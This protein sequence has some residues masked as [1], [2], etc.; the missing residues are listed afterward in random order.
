MAEITVNKKTVKEYLEQGQKS[1]FIIPEYQREYSWTND[2]CETLWEDVLNF[3]NSKDKEY[4]IGTIV[5]FKNDDGNFEIIDGQQRTT[6]LFLLLRAIY[7]KLETMTEDDNVN[8]LKG[9]IAP[10][11]WKINNITRK[12]NDFSQTNIKSL[13]ATDTH[14][15]VFQ[16]IL[17]KGKTESNN[18]NFGQNYQYF[19][20]KI[21][22]FAGNEPF[23]F[24]EFIVQILERLI[25][26]PIEADNQDSALTIFSTLNDRGLS[27]SDSD[28][29]K[30][31]I[32]K[33]LTDDDKEAFIENWKSLSERVGQLK[34]V[35][36]IDNLFYCYMMYIRAGNGDTDTTTPGLRKFYSR[37]NFEVLNQKDL[38][39]NILYLADLF[40]YVEQLSGIEEW[41][42]EFEINKNIDIL[43][44]FPNEWWKYPLC[45]FYLNHRTRTDF[46]FKFQI[47]LEQFVK[48]LLTK[49]AENPSVNNIKGIVLEINKQVYG[50]LS[51]SLNLNVK[52]ED[53]RRNLKRRNKFTKDILILYTYLSGEV[54]LLPEITEIEHILPQ[55]NKGILSRNELELAKEKVDYLGNKILLEKKINIKA[56]NNYFENKKAEYHKSKIVLVQKL[57][58]QIQDKFSPKMID[59]RQVEIENTILN[60]FKNLT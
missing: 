40:E 13:S 38:F 7:S 42:N 59:D 23:K 10:C 33:K 3:Y 2:E 22:D 27:L 24:Y 19:G 56:S 37:D 32:Y 29:F 48:T 57:A 49:F 36:N 50:S 12:A 46:K 35:K 34:V 58:N 1:K 11:L 45:T 4:F 47:F 44:N 25:L 20:Q 14:N 55:N 6:T 8:G 31:K 43:R 17:E 52:E 54:D 30:A 5:T 51:F 26:M 53:I 15:S 18:N 21:T 28:I 60:F 16:E 9:Q 41:Q 39:R